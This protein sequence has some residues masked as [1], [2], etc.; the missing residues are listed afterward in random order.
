MFGFFKQTTNRAPEPERTIPETLENPEKYDVDLIFKL[1]EDAEHKMMSLLKEEGGLTHGLNELLAGTEFTLNEILQVEKQLILLDSNVRN[2]QVSVDAVS[3]SL[4]ETSQVIVDTR[5]GYAEMSQKMDAVAD[6]FSQFYGLFNQL[7]IQ[8]GEIQKFA[9]MI[10]NV[11]N[12]TRLL[13]LNASIEAARVGAAGVG[14]AV[15]A[16]EIKKL[17]DE[18]QRNATDIIGSLQLMT[19]TINQLNE[20]SSTGGKVVLDTKNM[21]AVSEKLIDNIVIAEG[22]VR[23]RV[24]E[25]KD[26]QGAN[27]EAIRQ[28]TGNLS[29]VAVKSDSETRRLEDLVSGIQKKSG[30]YTYIL[31]H[32]DQIR[33]LRK[34]R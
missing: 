3:N 10:T 2:T 1:A 26:S 32:L 13:S 6:L 15:V 23:D 22:R 21:V 30:Y 11:A 31:N 28:I 12:Q 18:S 4:E 33:I 24:D 27:L 9:N 7:S 14:F 16:D 29:N 8:Y 20:K 34:A 19:E 17:S 25:V 5:R